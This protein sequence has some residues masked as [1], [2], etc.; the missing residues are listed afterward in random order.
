M[1]FFQYLIPSAEHFIGAFHAYVHL[2]S[3]PSWPLTPVFE[4]SNG[5]PGAVFPF[6]PCIS[7]LFAV[8]WLTFSVVTLFGRTQS[9][10]VRQ[11]LRFRHIISVGNGW[12]AWM[13]GVDGWRA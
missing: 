12:E 8:L 6:F 2:I 11:G 4:Q 1:Y 7:F 9:R 10:L 13:G 3:H 5:T